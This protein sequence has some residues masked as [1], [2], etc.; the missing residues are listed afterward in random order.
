[1][2]TWMMVATHRDTP[3]LD[4]SPPES[5]T[6]AVVLS[7]EP[8]SPQSLLRAAGLFAKKSWG[9]N[10]LCDQ[11]V[12]A[13]IAEAAV[14]P[15]CPVV[16]LGAGLGAL[17]YHLCKRADRVIAIERD[18]ELA[19]LLRQYLSEATN[20]EVREADAARLDYDALRKEMQLPLTV[21]GNL[22]YQL[23]S[24]ILVNMA[25][26]GAV[27]RAVVLV[28]R[29]V[30]ARLVAA[31]PGRT[32]GLLSVLVQRAFAA[33]LVLNVPAGA[34]HPAPKVQSTVVRLT[35]HKGEVGTQN[36]RRLVTAARAAFSARRKTLRNA[37]MGGLKAASEPVVEALEA[38]DLDPKARAETLCL[39]DFE[40]LGQT[41]AQAGIIDEDPRA[42]ALRQDA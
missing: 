6:T 3:H 42:S 9:Q 11:R 7:F 31:P 18:R 35:R 2:P 4:K 34:F 23:S 5:D 37:L 28:Q 1:L 25:D 16:E 14:T 24:R 30:A 10:F 22:P 20:L 40:R 39:S 29:E 36:D 21:V 26:A 8:Q 12:L 27:D 19:P 13:A 41:L 17:T 38:A 15:D 33:E 32:Y